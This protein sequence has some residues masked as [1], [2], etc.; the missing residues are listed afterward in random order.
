M[1]DIDNR[2]LE[3]NSGVYFHLRQLL[4]ATGAIMLACVVTVPQQRSSRELAGINGPVRTVRVEGRQLLAVTY[5][6]WEVMVYTTIYDDKGRVL[7]N[8]EYLPGGNPDTKST[9]AYDERGNR[10]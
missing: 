6:Q 1:K 7:E 2:A 9:T 5:H 4:L 10:L 3:W 8:V